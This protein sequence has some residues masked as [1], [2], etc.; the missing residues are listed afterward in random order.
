MN[1]FTILTLVL[2]FLFGAGLGSFMSVIIYRLHA[3]ERGILK[4]RSHCPDC[5]TPLQ[6]KDLLPLLSYLTLRG[7]CRYCSTKISFMYPL[8][9]ISM[10][11]LL[12]MLFFKFP[13]LDQNFAFDYNFLFLYGLYTLYF[14]I[15]VFTFYYDLRYLTI[16]DEIL[17]PAILIGLLATLSPLT[18]TLIDAFIGAVIPLL[19]FGLQI[20]LSKGE[21]IGGGDLRV[22]AFMGVI[23]GWKLVLVALALSYFIGGF[24]SIL[25]VI[26]E[27]KFAGVK[28][29]FA[30]FLV[31]GTLVTIFY[32]ESILQWY[33]Q[34]L[35]F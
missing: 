35:G 17:L 32:G 10:G 18:L 4:G 1:M 8:L 23:L 6:A 24:A 7:K 25:I 20:G 15:L 12:V 3:K 27:G 19:F 9:E 28:V 30:P 22:G 33:L 29:P 14:F 5:R 2:L 26:K 21:W 11:I 34:S 31:T 13:F 16:S